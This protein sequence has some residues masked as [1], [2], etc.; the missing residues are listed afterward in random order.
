MPVYYSDKGKRRTIGGLLFA[1][2]SFSSSKKEMQDTAKRLRK[3]GHK[4]RVVRT[5]KVWSVYYRS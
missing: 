4:A 1:P 3:N 5:G 2:H